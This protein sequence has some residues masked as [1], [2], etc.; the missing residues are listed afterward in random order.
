MSFH[1]DF[2]QRGYYD[3]AG[4]HQMLTLALD[5]FIRRMERLDDKVWNNEHPAIYANEFIRKDYVDSMKKI[6]R[7][8]MDKY[9]KEDSIGHTVSR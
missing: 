6:R 5:H 8:L 9:S 3:Y 4:E 1:K 7:A 2:H